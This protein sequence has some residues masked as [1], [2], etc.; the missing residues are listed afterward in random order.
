[1]Y[2][3]VCLNVFLLT[4]SKRKNHN[5]TILEEAYRFY[6]KIIL[7]GSGRLSKLAR[8]LFSYYSAPLA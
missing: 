6:S 1:M 7:K 8:A 2:K 3:N 4:K 5:R